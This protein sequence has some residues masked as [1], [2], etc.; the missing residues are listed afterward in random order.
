MKCYK[1]KQEIDSDSLYCDQCGEKLYICPD[2]HI[3][4]KGEGKRC[5][6]CGKPLVAASELRDSSVA[7]PTQEP[8]SPTPPEPTP[9]APVRLVCRAEN[10]TLDLMDGALIGRVEGPY[11]PKLGRLQFVSARHARLTREGDH[12]IIADVGSRNGTAV[13]GEW[14]FSPLPFKTGDVVRI[15]N[16]YDFIA[17]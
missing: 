17:E 9:K 6:K 5:G 16:F 12:W 1:C 15:A 7:T 10:I 4:G 13:N 8:A 11:A 3:P 14:C 2:C